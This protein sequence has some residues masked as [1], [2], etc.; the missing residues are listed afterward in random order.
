M[1]KNLK[2]ALLLKLEVPFDYLV[3]ITLR[4][5]EADKESDVEVVGAKKNFNN[6]KKRQLNSKF[7]G[8]NP[9]KKEKQTTSVAKTPTSSRGECYNCGS[10]DHYAN[11]CPKP[12]FCRYCKS[13]GHLLSSCPKLPNKKEGKLNVVQVPSNTSLGQ[14]ISHSILNDI[15]F[16]IILFVFFLIWVH[17]IILYQKNLLMLTSSLMPY[18]NFAA[19]G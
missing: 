14:G 10:K 8:P 17:L 9:N 13:S 2:K 7:K 5:E 19:L 6:N 3:D 1:N 11:R 15:C 4:L 16:V 18:K 12:L